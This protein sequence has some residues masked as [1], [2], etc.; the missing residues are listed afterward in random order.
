MRDTMNAESSLQYAN[1]IKSEIV[2]P[3]FLT[4]FLLSQFI[5]DIYRLEEKI[6]TNSKSELS[7]YRKRALKSGK[8]TVSIS[9]K[10]AGDRTEIFKLMGTYY[11]L[12]GKQKKA[13]KWWSKS[14]AE[15]EHLGARLELSRTYMEVGKRLLDP[16]SKFNELN[17]IKT[18][19]YLEKA[20]AMFEEMDL[21]LDLDE[22]DKIASDS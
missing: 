12:I 9:R 8:K 16:K 14:I 1:N 15:G 19:E 4:D 21:Q 10:A 17:G 11:W 7:E 20:R 3:Y 6:E 5:F 2:P 18:E 22:L 13:L